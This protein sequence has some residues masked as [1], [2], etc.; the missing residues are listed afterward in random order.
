MYEISVDENSRPE[1]VRRGTVEAGS[2]GRAWARESRLGARKGP[3]GPAGT[4]ATIS[5]IPKGAPLLTSLLRSL[6]HVIAAACCALAS[7]S[8]SPTSSRRL[9][10]CVCSAPRSALLPELSLPPSKRIDRASDRASDRV[11]SPSPLPFLSPLRV[12]YLTL[13]HFRALS[14]PRLSVRDSGLRQRGAVAG[15]LLRSFSLMTRGP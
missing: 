11:R 5:R 10:A 2:E 13:A 14:A 7:P 4:L 3:H 8:P 1:R 12:L 15:I 9:P 6:H